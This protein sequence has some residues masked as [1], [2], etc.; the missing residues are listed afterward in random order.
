MRVVSEPR[1]R[2][3]PTT[4]R[5]GPESVGLC[6]DL[7]EKQERTRVLGWLLG[8][9]SRK[10]ALRAECPRKIRGIPPHLLGDL[11]VDDG[12]INIWTRWT[13]CKDLLAYYQSACCPS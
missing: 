11:S 3:L 4:E 6:D 1:E 12:T 5:E 2:H 9:P 13:R 7:W 8:V 10:S